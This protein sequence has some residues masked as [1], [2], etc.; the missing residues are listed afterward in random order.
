ML[1]IGKYGNFTEAN[2]DGQL[3]SDRSRIRNQ[4][5]HSAE[6]GRTLVSLKFLQIIPIFVSRIR[7]KASH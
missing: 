6:I 3:K 4:E 2:K 5:F 1:E 7:D